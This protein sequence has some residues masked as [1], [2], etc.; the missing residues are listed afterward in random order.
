MSDSDISGERSINVGGENLTSEAEISWIIGS[1]LLRANRQ[2]TRA[3]EEHLHQLSYPDANREVEAY[4]RQALAEHKQ[5]VEELE[6]ALEV[7]EQKH[8]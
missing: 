3:L 5:I 4:L 2:T 8:E 1:T 6:L 7:V